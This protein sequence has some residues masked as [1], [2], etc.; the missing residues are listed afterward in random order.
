MS[1]PTRDNPDV[2]HETSDVSVRGIL[3]P[4]GALV[5]VALVI[6]VGS[7]LLFDYLLARERRAKPDLFPLAAEER[8]RLAPPRPDGPTPESWN[9]IKGPPQPPEG[10]RLEGVLRLEGRT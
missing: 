2:R 3:Y 1:E 6:H 9:S 10:P 4:A 5:A 7:W 8:Q